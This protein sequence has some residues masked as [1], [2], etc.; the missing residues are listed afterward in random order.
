MLKSKYWNIK[1]SII[2]I[3]YMSKLTFYVLK[4]SSHITNKQ[5]F[6]TG[7]KQ[8]RRANKKRSSIRKLF[9][10]SRRAELFF[11]VHVRFGFTNTTIRSTNVVC[12]MRPFYVAAFKTAR[13]GENFHV[14]E[15]KVPGKVAE[16]AVML[17]ISR[18]WTYLRSTWSFVPSSAM[19]TYETKEYVWNETIFNLHY[20]LCYAMVCYATLYYAMVGYATLYYAILRFATLS[21]TVLCCGLYGD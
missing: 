2:S 18:L 5:T 4:I 9:W 1:N 10:R 11:H 15:M 21:Y 12:I 19:E 14:F 6:G 16:Q 13:A 17:C 3:S 8:K 7:T 20:L